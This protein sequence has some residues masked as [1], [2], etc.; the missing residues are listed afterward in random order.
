MFKKKK[1][2]RVYHFYN[3]ERIYSNNDIQL[4]RYGGLYRERL[5]GMNKYHV[6]HA[7]QGKK[8]V[9][10]KRAYCPLCYFDKLLRFFRR[11]RFHS[12]KYAIQEKIISL[13][14]LSQELETMKNNQQ[15]MGVMHW[16]SFFSGNSYLYYV[17]K[18]VTETTAAL[19]PTFEH[20]YDVSVLRDADWFDSLVNYYLKNRV[21]GV[22]GC[23][24]GSYKVE[25]KR[26]QFKWPQLK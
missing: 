10:C 19:Y 7:W 16:N 12:R 8:T 3:G 17:D 6:C 23:F 4:I 22:R 21:S 24:H 26:S 15:I 2:F 5:Q 25:K 14:S 20:Y 11:V 1:L 9:P 18:R 13:S